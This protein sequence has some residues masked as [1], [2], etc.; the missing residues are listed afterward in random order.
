MVRR[1]TAARHFRHALARFKTSRGGSAAIQFA[2]VAPLFFAVLFAIIEVALVYF[3]GQILETGTQD[4]G[5]LIFTHQAQD[6][7]KLAA[8]FNT[9]LCSRVSFILDCTKLVI[10]VESYPAGTVIT[11]YVPLD[12]NGNFDSS[13]AQY[14]PPAAGST[15][16]VLVRTFYKWQLFFPQ[17]GFNISNLSEGT[18]LLSATAA[19]RVEPGS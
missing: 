17:M 5:R 2:F 19:F 7:G 16:I 10:D 13:K 15:N 1:V 11:P 6:S 9:D 8:D 18:R 12:S 14:S 4:S 3:A